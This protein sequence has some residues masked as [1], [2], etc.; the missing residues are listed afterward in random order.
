MTAGKGD[1]KRV[2]LKKGTCSR[3]LFYILDREFGHVK[4]QQERA[5]DPLAGGVASQG[6][7]CGMLWGSALALGAEAF[8]RDNDQGRAIARTITATRQVLESFIRRA[9][10]ANCSDITSC[11]FT[12]KSGLVK[13]LITGKPIACFDLAAKWVPEAIQSAHE[14]LSDDMTD[15][16]QSA[17]SCASEVVRKMGGCGED[18][19]MVAGFAG[20]LGLSGH[21]CGALSAAIWMNTLLRVREER[22]KSSLSDPAAERIIEAFYKETDYTMECSAIC[23]R[24]F[25]TIGEHAEFINNGGCTKLIQVLADAGLAPDA[26]PELKTIRE[27]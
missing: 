24:R 13:Y 19:V 6:Y 18:V 10:N 1:T 27:S 8:R 7:Q 17:A 12:K 2:F 20:G 11:D 4:E 16:P 23:G 25:A 22:Y 15:M 14:G 3:T 9:K 26:G 21:G 5:S